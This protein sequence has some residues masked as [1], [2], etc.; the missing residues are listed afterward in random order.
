MSFMVFAS[1]FSERRGGGF[2]TIQVLVPIPA[3]GGDDAMDVLDS[4][5]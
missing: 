2:I 1:I 3:G 5:I 4:I